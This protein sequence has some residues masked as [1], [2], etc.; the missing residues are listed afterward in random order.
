MEERGITRQRFLGLSSLG[1]AALAAA[2]STDTDDSPPAG[3]VPGGFTHRDAD[4]N[5]VRLH[6]VIGGEGDP[7]VLLHGFPETWYAWREVMPALAKE[8]TVIAPDLRGIGE[9]S[10]AESGY[11][12]TTMAEDV[13]RLVRE[14]GFEEVSVVGHDL[15]AWVAYACARRHREEVAHLAFMGAAL[16]GFTL[17]R[18]LDFR[19]PGQGLGHL[20]F[21]MQREVPETLIKGRERY[22]LT[23]FIG[24]EAVTRTAAIDEYVRAYSRDGRLGA[25]LEQYR[26]IYQDAEDNRKG[27]MPKLEMPVLAL[28]SGSSSRS[29]ESMRKVAENV[30]GKSIQGAGHYM[31]EEQPEQV[32]ELL[33]DFLGR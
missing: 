19:E 13:Y 31:H 24:S 18:L 9:S 14:L 1:M 10:L 23:Q 22:Y 15:G 27:A 5:G 16:P 7:V 11:D 25:A 32:A 33:L 8:H 12:K 17:E 20:V 26:A 2:C 29:L 30:E 21:F 3:A 4:V 6:Y 28:D